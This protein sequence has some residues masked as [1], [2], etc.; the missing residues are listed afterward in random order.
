MTPEQCTAVFMRLKRM[1]LPG[2]PMRP[3]HQDAV[4]A[5]WSRVLEPIRAEVEALANRLIESCDRWPSIKAVR[6]HAYAV[7]SRHLRLVPGT[8]TCRCG[9]GRGWITGPSVTKVINGVERVYGSVYPC[10][11]CRAEQYARWKAG[12]FRPDDLPGSEDHG[13]RRIEGAKPA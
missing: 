1:E 6:E 3:D 11:T 9:E 4:V 7:P 5:E 12:E 13:P 10:P 8:F 2:T